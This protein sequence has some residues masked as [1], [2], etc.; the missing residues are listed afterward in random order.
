MSVTFTPTQKQRLPELNAKDETLNKTFN[1]SVE[2]DNN[3]REEETRRGRRNK[4]D[5]QDLLQNRRHPLLSL[6]VKRITEWHTEEMG[7]TQVNTPI[8]IPKTM[9]EKMGITW[10]HPLRQQVFWVDN[11]KCLR[12]MLAPNL[13]EMMKSIHRITRQ[14]VRIFEIGP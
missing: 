13:Y 9:L 11:N 6:V 8:I 7:F 4:E 3:Y 10:D 12:P 14:P 5:L 1:D 2:R